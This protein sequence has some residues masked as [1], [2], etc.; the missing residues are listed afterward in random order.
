MIE[1]HFR[2]GEFERLDR[3]FLNNQTSL[4]DDDR[5]LHELF[6]N[7]P[8]KAAALMTIL[9]QS[10][11]EFNNY[12]RDSF[13]GGNFEEII[14]NARAHLV[15][16]NDCLKGYDDYIRFR[17]L[18]N[19]VMTGRLLR[20]LDLGYTTEHFEEDYSRGLEEGDFLKVL[21]DLEKV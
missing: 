16:C 14:R 19:C 20:E 5:F 11:A 3:Y 7:N 17:A 13:F 8:N 21:C 4:E 1:V 10:R 6:P 9:D 18:R 15:S 2:I 12:E